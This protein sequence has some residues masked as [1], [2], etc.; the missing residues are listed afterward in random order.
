[1]VILASI[2]TD[3]DISFIKR[4]DDKLPMIA[5]LFVDRDDFFGRID[6]INKLKDREI[7]RTCEGTKYNIIIHRKIFRR[8][9]GLIPGISQFLTVGEKAQLSRVSSEF[10]TFE[11]LEKLR[12]RTIIISELPKSLFGKEE[13]Q[14]LFNQ[15]RKVFSDYGVVE[16]GPLNRQGHLYVILKDENSVDRVI[17]WAKHGEKEGLS[18]KESRKVYRKLHSKSS[19]IPDEY[20]N[21]VAN[22]DKK[23][24]VIVRVA[25]RV[26]KEPK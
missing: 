8:F 24:Y 5:E 7:V 3:E 20:R 22:I 13:R 2:N 12:K 17:N 21:S 9:P 19:Y 25:R 14:K 11:D 16:V 23:D 15:T 10:S 1:M 26:E 18:P 4:Y 6:V